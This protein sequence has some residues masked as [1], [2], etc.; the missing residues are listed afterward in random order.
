M[1]YA[2]LLPASLNLSQNLS[3]SSNCRFPDTRAS[4]FSIRG[5]TD[6]Q[7][8]FRDLVQSG[9]LILRG[10]TGVQPAYLNIIDPTRPFAGEAYRAG[11]LSG[12]LGKPQHM[13]DRLK[14]C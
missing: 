2:D 6:V 7:K 11:Y 13:G 12:S 3:T 8:C 14:L 4:E 5:K 1:I 9:F 10:S